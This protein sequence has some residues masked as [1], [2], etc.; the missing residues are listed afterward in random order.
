VTFEICVE[1]EIDVFRLRTLFGFVVNV[2][3]NNLAE[4]LSKDDVSPGQGVELVFHR[5]YSVDDFGHF[6]N[7]LVHGCLDFVDVVSH[8]VDNIVLFLF[9]PVGG[10]VD[11]AS[12]VVDPVSSIVYFVR[13]FI[14]NV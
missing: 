2:L 6:S 14:L 10:V 13:N 7:V 9:G 8:T 5:I 1:I 4:R 12:S 11:I 3:E